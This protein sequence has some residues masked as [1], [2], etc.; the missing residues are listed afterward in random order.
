MRNYDAPFS[1]ATCASPY[2]GSSLSGCCSRYRRRCVS[3]NGRSAST[4]IPA[5]CAFNCVAFV[6]GICPIT[7]SFSA[8]SA[9]WNTTSNLHAHKACGAKGWSRGPNLRR[10]CVSRNALRSAS[11]LIPEQCAFNCVAF[12]SGICPITGR[13]SAASDRWNTTSNLHAHKACGAKR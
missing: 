7:G 2:V 11:K 12:V 5:R 6:S 13:F 10:R 1:R 8:A 4:L 9:R 3:R